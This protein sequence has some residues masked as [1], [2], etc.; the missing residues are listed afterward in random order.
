MPTLVHGD[1]VVLNIRM[2]LDKTMFTIHETIKDFVR[3]DLIFFNFYFH[4]TLQKSKKI[5]NKYSYNVSYFLKIRIHQ[6]NNKR[7]IFL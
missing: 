2:I 4:V 7:N 5:H 1:F 3:F 6:R